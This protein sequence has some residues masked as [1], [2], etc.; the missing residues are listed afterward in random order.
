MVVSLAPKLPQLVELV[1][2][3]ILN[4]DHAVFALADLLA[5]L[6]ATAVLV[7]ALL[8]A[9]RAGGARAVVAVVAPDEDLVELLV[10]QLAVGLALR[11]A[12]RAC[13]ES[14]S[15]DDRW[16]KGVH[17]CSLGLLCLGLCSCF[18]LSS[19]LAC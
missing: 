9:V 19:C 15:C 3:R 5:F 14:H 8:G 1:D 10:A 12:L 4:L 17:I 16:V 11:G 13:T 6:L 7:R 18:D 2:L